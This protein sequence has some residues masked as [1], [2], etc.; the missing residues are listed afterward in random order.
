M[1]KV[2]LKNTGAENLGDDHDELGSILEG[3]NDALYCKDYSSGEMETVFTE[4]RAHIKE[5]FRREEAWMTKADYPGQESH[6]GQHQ[7]ILECLDDLSEQF[8]AFPTLDTGVEAFSFANEY[9]VDHTIN[10]DR[11]LGRYMDFVKHDRAHKKFL[12]HRL[13]T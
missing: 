3:L 7:K 11:L 4:L 5:H 1:L 8:R 10:A 9:L 12:S 2:L 13:F 6:K